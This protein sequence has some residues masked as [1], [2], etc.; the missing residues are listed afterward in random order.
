[1]NIK[2][3]AFFIILSWIPYYLTARS[4]ELPERFI[5]VERTK[6]NQTVTYT[7]KPGRLL[8]IL[9]NQGEKIFLKDYYLAETYIYTSVGDTILF[10]DILHIKGPVK[11]NAERKVLGA[12]MAIGTIPIGFNFVYMVAWGGGP[13]LVAAAPFIGIMAVGINLTGPRKFKSKNDWEVKLILPEQ[14]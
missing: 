8:R 5:A 10:A 6:S 4:T 3:I 14:K 1:M 7:F 13:V 2:A 9:N 11:G 12:T